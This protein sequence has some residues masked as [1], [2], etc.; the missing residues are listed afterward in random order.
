MNSKSKMRE[1][2]F[3]KKCQNNKKHNNKKTKKKCKSLKEKHVQ[4]YK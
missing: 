1:Q 2:K 4:N 3:T